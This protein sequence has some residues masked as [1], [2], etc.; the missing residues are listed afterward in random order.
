MQLQV[1]NQIKRAAD[2]KFTKTAVQ[3]N[4]S[5][6]PQPTPDHKDKSTQ[7]S[8][9]ESVKAAV[10][11]FTP[12]QK[13][14]EIEVKNGVEVKGVLAEPLS[15]G[16]PS[17]PLE[18]QQS[19][20]PS[21]HFSEEWPTEPSRPLAVFARGVRIIPDS[22]DANEYLCA[23][24]SHLE[25]GVL[26]SV[27]RP[28]LNNLRAS[29][30]RKDYT[31][32]RNKL[33]SH[34]IAFGRYIYPLL[35]FHLSLCTY[36]CSLIAVMY[37]NRYETNDQGKYVRYG[38]DGSN[39]VGSLKWLGGEMEALKVPAF[40]CIYL[41]G[42]LID[43]IKKLLASTQLRIDFLKSKGLDQ[44]SDIETEEISSNPAG[45]AEP[46]ETAPATSKPEQENII[47]ALALTESKRTN[48]EEEVPEVVPVEQMDWT[49]V[50]GHRASLLL[51]LDEMAAVVSC[52]PPTRIGYFFPLGVPAA[53]TV[54]AI[55]E[56]SSGLLAAIVSHN[57]GFTYLSE[58][59]E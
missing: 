56:S 34:L 40:Q 51:G 47:S 32:R 54:N 55:N 57:C 52:E 23:P 12:M 4:T 33:R 21:V 14:A 1:L 26:L 6:L 7:Q 10:A 41:A 16:P 9:R 45:T 8:E 25:S 38:L 46:K 11:V 39:T 13:Q 22:I 42:S 29:V 15:A 3:L 50:K 53:A 43:N 30:L 19:K 27:H 58:A 24:M 36:I 2:W 35:F 28:N 48:P 37:E 18:L 17:L 5:E 44:D 31:L 20:A 59:C 49:Q